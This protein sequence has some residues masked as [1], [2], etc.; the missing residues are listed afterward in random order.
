MFA[1]RCSDKR[2]VIVIMILCIFFYLVLKNPFFVAPWGV[3]L[4][5][6]VFLSTKNKTT[7]KYVSGQNPRGFCMVCKSFQARKLQ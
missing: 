2:I 3:C 1:C 5:I 6:T 4:A 7:V